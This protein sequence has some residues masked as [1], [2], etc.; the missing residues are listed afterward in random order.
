MCFLFSIGPC[1]APAAPVH[2]KGISRRT[3]RG[4][5]CSPTGC[6]VSV[7]WLA[8]LVAIALHHN[9]HHNLHHYA[10]PKHAV[11]VGVAVHNPAS[12]TKQGYEVADEAALAALMAAAGPT[13][14]QHTSFV[15]FA[16]FAEWWQV[17][18]P[19]CFCFPRRS[20]NVPPLKLPWP[21]LFM[22]LCF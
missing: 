6:S 5:L 10:Q 4:V 15:G 18:A 1:R 8:V 19:V 2:A 20:S 14:R 21:F 13:L 7:C 17:L 16:V 11:R 3:F 9:L 22:C 12:P